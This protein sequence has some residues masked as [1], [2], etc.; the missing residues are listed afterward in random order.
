MAHALSVVLDAKTKN[1]P[2]NTPVL[3]LLIILDHGRGMAILS[4]GGGQLRP[5][6]PPEQTNICEN[7]TFHHTTFMVGNYWILILA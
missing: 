4:G 7:I 2:I 3:D 6:P 1:V 5:P